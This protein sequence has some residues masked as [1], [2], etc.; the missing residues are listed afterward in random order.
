MM[1]ISDMS[2]MAANTAATPDPTAMASGTP[3]QSSGE[4]TATLS[5]MS[6]S[7]MSSLMESPLNARGCTLPVMFKPGYNASSLPPDACS[8]TT[9]P[10][11]TV[12]ANA[13][14]GCL[15]LNLVNAGSVSRLSVSLE[16]HSMF[17]YAADGLYV[18][19]QKVKV[20]QNSNPIHY[21]GTNLFRC[22]ICQLVSGTR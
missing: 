4:P 21:K 17:V 18:D 8:N 16:G 5:A 11:F 12:T 19:A 7:S 6:M 20:S 10:L 1:E 14:L 3:S 22:Y 13:T 15:A 2:A 9:T